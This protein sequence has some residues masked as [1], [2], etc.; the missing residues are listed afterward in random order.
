MQYYIFLFIQ[1]FEN[2]YIKMP[3][4]MSLLF[5]ILFIVYSYCS[6]CL[7]S[8][9]LNL[10]E[11]PSICYGL[12]TTDEN[13]Y[14]S[15]IYDSSAPS[16]VELECQDFPFNLYHQFSYKSLSKRCISNYITKKCETIRCSNFPIDRC[17]EFGRNGN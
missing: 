1:D 2:F 13:N 5:S 16:C 3:K 14:T 7:N 15:C 10:N 12:S 6:D 9:S 8:S 17:N 4:K 11:D